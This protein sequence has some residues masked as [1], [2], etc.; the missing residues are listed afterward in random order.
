PAPTTTKIA[1]KGATTSQDKDG[2]RIIKMTKENL[3]QMAEEE[4][5][6]KRGGGGREAEIRPEDVRFADYRKKE[7]V[8]LPKKKRLPVGKTLNRTQI[9]ETKAEKRIVEMT[10]SIT[11]GDLASQLSVKATDVIRKL[12]GMG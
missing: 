11:V 9:T 2:F 12:M 10:D 3:D 8:F 1:P 5:A 7:M 4:A 6:K